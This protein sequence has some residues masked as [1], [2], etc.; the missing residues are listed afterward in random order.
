MKVEHEYD[1]GGAWVYLAAWDVHRVRIF[2]HCEG[3]SG[4]KPFDRLVNQVML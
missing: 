1:R 3:K 2:G 4:I